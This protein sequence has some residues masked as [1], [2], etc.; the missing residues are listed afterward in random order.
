MLDA[1]AREP[2]TAMANGNAAAPVYLKDAE[3]NAGETKEN[4]NGTE[5]VTVNVTVGPGS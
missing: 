5:T 3:F 2:S 1:R 4:D